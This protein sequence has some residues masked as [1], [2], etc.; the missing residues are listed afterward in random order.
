M[1]VCVCVSVLLLCV[2][3][4]C[5]CVCVCLLRQCVRLAVVKELLRSCLAF[6]H[7]VG[8]KT[9]GQRLC[10]KVERSPVTQKNPRYSTRVIGRKE[11][12]RVSGRKSILHSFCCDGEEDTI[13]CEF[14][15]IFFSFFFFFSRHGRGSS[16]R[17]GISD[18]GVGL[19]TLSSLATIRWLGRR[20]AVPVT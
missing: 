6:F 18:P 11:I 16:E 12:S 10:L 15:S 1:C 14:S 7:R 4:V 5:V 9:C 8:M 17:R 3:T 20:S 19:F 13:D 2:C